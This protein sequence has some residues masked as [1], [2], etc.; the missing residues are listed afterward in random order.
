MYQNALAILIAT[1]I[2]NQFWINALLKFHASVF[3]Q[4]IYKPVS[5]V[6]RIEKAW[7]FKYC[8]KM[9]LDLKNTGQIFRGNETRFFISKLVSFILLKMDFCKDWKNLYALLTYQNNSS[10]SEKTFSQK[11]HDFFVTFPPQQHSPTKYFTRRTHFSKQ[12]LKS[13]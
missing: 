1:N 4:L 10:K 7:D 9:R 12:K 3:L 13:S 5:W 6:A 11:S 2:F 8:L